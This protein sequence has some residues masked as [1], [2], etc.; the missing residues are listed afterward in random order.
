MLHKVIIRVTYQ[1]DS[2]TILA[3]AFKWEEN[4]DLSLYSNLTY[5]RFTHS[6]IQSV[7]MEVVKE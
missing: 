6:T 3:D 4:G 7:Y 5:W 2:I 1:F